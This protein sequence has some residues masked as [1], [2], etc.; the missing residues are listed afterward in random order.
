MTMIQELLNRMTVKAKSEG[1]LGYLGRPY[2]RTPQA[3]K[4]MVLAAIDLGISEEDLYLWGTSRDARH[5]SNAENF[6]VEAFKK[7]I[8]RDLPA[9]LK[10]VR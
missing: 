7:A 10:E 1:V 8:Q 6:S 3:D 5:F 2:V 4:N 9:L